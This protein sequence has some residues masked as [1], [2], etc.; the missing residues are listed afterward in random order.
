MNRKNKKKIDEIEKLRRKKGK[1]LENLFV[2][3]NKAIDLLLEL[4]IDKRDI[5][6]QLTLIE[7]KL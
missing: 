6:D 3:D 1:E 7:I 5:E 2:M 4:N